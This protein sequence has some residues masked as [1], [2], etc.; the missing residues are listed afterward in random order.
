MRRPLA[1]LLLA[2][3][4]GSAGCAQVRPWERG[5]QADRRMRA[6]PC[7]ERAAAREHVHAVREGAQG[8]SNAQGSGC[9]CD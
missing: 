1:L 2:G 5:V 4:L 7:P 3:L 6:A 8:A 9:G